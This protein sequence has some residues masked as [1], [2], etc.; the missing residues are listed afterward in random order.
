MERKNRQSLAET[1]K[2]TVYGI[3]HTFD[4]N[5]EIFELQMAN[6]EPLYILK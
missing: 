5:D 1:K 6:T 3:V 2:F 4:P